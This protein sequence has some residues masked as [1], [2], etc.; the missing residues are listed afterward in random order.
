LRRIE[1]AIDALAND[2]GSR[3]SRKRGF[4]GGTFGIP[5]S[6]REDDWLIIWEYDGT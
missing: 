6:D 5:V 4:R 3:D 2:P 1:D